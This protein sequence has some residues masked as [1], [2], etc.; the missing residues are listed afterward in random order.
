MDSALWYCSLPTHTAANAVYQQPVSRVAVLRCLNLY[1]FSE[2]E[3]R[4]AEQLWTALYGTA[5]SQLIQQ[6][7]QPSSTLSSSTSSSTSRSYPSVPVLRMP[8][9]ARPWDLTYA[10]HAAQ[11]DARLDAFVANKQKQMR[12]ER[13]TQKRVAEEE[14]AALKE[15]KKKK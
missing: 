4:A 7:Q 11:S 2:Q 5:P 13:K 14:A 9:A 6:H 3:E 10:A 12:I 15:K 1:M 8:H